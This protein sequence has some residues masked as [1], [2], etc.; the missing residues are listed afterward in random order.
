[1]ADAGDLKSRLTS[2]QQAAPQRSTAKIACVYARLPRLLRAAP[3]TGAKGNANPTDTTTD[4]S[5]TAL[6]HG[7]MAPPQKRDLTRDGESR[8]G[9]PVRGAGHSARL[10]GRSK[11]YS[12]TGAFASRLFLT[13][14]ASLLLRVGHKSG[15]SLR[16]KGKVNEVECGEKVALCVSVRERRASYRRSGPGALPY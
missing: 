5:E 8:H 7:K 9:L 6:V 16:A 3:R 14:Y 10:P 12:V 4:T 15:H 2:L 11:P 13:R 1:M